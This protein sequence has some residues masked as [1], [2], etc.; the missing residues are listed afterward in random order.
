MPNPLFHTLVASVLCTSVLAL[1]GCGPSTDESS[2]TDAANAADSESVERI[3]LPVEVLRA[4]AGTISDVI[5]VQARLEASKRQE[6]VN[7]S[8]GIIAELP[9]VN[10]QIVEAGELLVALDPL[11]EDADQ[12]VDAQI[13]LQRAQRDLERLQVLEKRVAGAVAQVDLD[14]ALDNRDDAA[15][16]VKKAERDAQIVALPHHFRSNFG[17]KRFLANVGSFFGVCPLAKSRL[18][19]HH[20]RY[21]RNHCPTLEVGLMVDVIPL[22]GEAAVGSILTLPASIDDQTGSGAVR[23]KIDNPPAP[24]ARRLCPDAH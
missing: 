3:A 16:A 22:G 1:A 14:D 8:N 17:S 20:R 9:V 2:A 21:P 11:P 18:I 23:V 10:G 15:L 12:L 24:G 4:D 7:L 6:I 13:D 5:E 19:Y